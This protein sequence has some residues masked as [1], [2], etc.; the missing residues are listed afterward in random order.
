[1]SCHHYNEVNIL[2]VISSWNYVP[3][4][5]MIVTEI[6]VAVSRMQTVIELGR[7]IRDRKTMPAKVGYHTNVLNCHSSLY[8]PS[9][10]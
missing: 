6:E 2:I 10:V 4:E 1:M 8:L 5:E 9:F 3:R 7:V